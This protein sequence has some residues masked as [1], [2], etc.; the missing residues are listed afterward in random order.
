MSEGI[1]RGQLINVPLIQ[2]TMFEKGLLQKDL[3]KLMEAEGSDI[4]SWLTGRINPTWPNVIK[5][6]NALDLPV[7]DMLLNY[8][9][10]E[11]VT[12]KVFGW[13]EEIE[14]GDDKDKLQRIQLASAVLEA[15]FAK[16]DMVAFCELQARVN[17]EKENEEKVEPEITK[18]EAL[19]L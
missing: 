18:E 13:L 9:N 15:H 5:I 1:M 17:K 12:K 2:Q 7:E 3:A 10:V 16:I 8:N 4:S 11:Q 6:A 14:K 19:D